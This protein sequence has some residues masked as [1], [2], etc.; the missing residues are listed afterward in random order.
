MKPK[1]HLGA[2]LAAALATLVGGAGA[3]AKDAGV[4]AKPQAASAPKATVAGLELIEFVPEEST[5]QRAPSTASIGSLRS[6]MGAPS[7]PAEVEPN[8]TAAT[9]TPISGTTVVYGGNVYPAADVDFYS[10]TA[11]AGDRIYAATQTLFDAS[12]SGDSVLELIGTDGTTV[13]EAD[14]NDGTFNASSSSIAGRQ[15]TVAGTYFLR[16]R[17]NV[18]TGTIRPYALHFRQQSAAP[19]AEVEPNNSTATATPIPASGHVS[20]AVT[21][22]SPGESD[23][24]SISLNAGDSVYL[25]LDMDPERDAVVWNGRLGFALFG[26]PPANQIL[27]ANDVNAGSAGDPNSE[28]FFFTVKDA[29]TYYVYVDSVVAAGLGVTATYNLNVSVLPRVTTGTCTTY[30]STD[31]PQTIPTGPGSVSSTITVPGNPRIA[32]LD[33]AINLNHTFMQD[34]DVHLISPAGN[35]NGLFTDI[36]AA[37]VGGTQ[38]LMDIVLDDEAALPP[39]FA[40]SAAFR[41][42]PELAYRLSWFDGSNAGGT[43]TLQLRDDA[44]GDGGTLNSWSITVCE[45]PPPQTC[46]AGTAQ[47]TVYS[48]DFEAGDGGFTHSG[49]QDEWERGLPAFAPITTC[50]SGTN[51][52]KTDLDNTYNASSSQDL[53]SPNINL[54]GLQPPVYVNWAQRYHMESTNFDHYNV[55]AR[56]VGGANPVNLFEWLDATMNNTVGNPTTTIGESSGWSQLS[57]RVDSLAGTNAELLFHVDSDTTV[58][59]AGVAIDDVSVTACRALSADLAITKTD[60]VASAVPG[61]TTTY[62]ITASNAGPDPVAAA[63]VADTFPAACVSPTWT[64]V[65]AGGGTCTANGSGNINQS[66]NLPAGGSVTFTA[67]CPIA[68]TATGSLAN[69]ATVSG[70]AIA[71]PTPGNNSATDTDTLTPQANLGIT[72]TNGVTQ[73][74]AGANTVYT[75]VASNAGPSAAP[76]ST[77][78]DTAPAACTTF[79]WTCVG[80]GGGICT[81]N[82]SGS[83]NDAVNLPVGGTATYTVTC[84]VSGAAAGN[85]VNTATVAAAGG[86][87]DPTPANNSATDTDTILSSQA[88]VSITK[89][90]GQASDVPGTSISYTIVA[91]NAGPAGAP[92]VT[93]ADTFAASL[94]GVTWTCTGAGG[95]TCTA[96]GAGNINDTANLPNGASVTYTVNATIAAN[97]TGTLSNTA[98]ATVGGAITDPNAAN[99]SAT[100]TTTLT[101]QADLAI[102]L[103][104]TPDPVTAGTNLTYV[105]T[106]TNNGPSDATDVAITLPLPANTTLVSATVSGG[107]CVATTCTFAGATAPGASRSVTYVVLVA[108]SVA[109]GSTITATASASSATT[110]PNGANNSASTTTDVI[111]VADLVIGLTSSA[112]QVLINVPV[113]FTATSQN[114]GPSDAQ[115]VSITLTLTPDFRYSSHVATGATCTTPQIGTTG[116]IVCT[117]AGATA[118]GVTR[119]LSVVAYSNNEG[120]T[121]VN[122][123]TTSNTTDPV[124]NNNAASQSVVVGFP[125]N[126][127]PTL[128]Q[129]GLLLLGLLVGLMGFVAI[130]RQG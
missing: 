33:V 66:V 41:I 83:I 87:T 115:N 17:H 22:V 8:G 71:D 103:T 6:A 47:T 102:T 108:A 42:Q 117:W 109:N 37:T 59:L 62:T 31:V 48:Q 82:G 46:P 130:R 39:A 26:N 24:F 57:R 77:V 2:V 105:A 79:T 20:G 75:I 36:G 123:S 116:A 60:G 44:T 112:T 101:P 38:T 97:A 120:N 106:A 51:C 53:L 52:W 4:P 35:D 111:A 67:L 64:C 124:A 95:G 11:A 76:G 107:T 129:Y 45:P 104:D 125:F 1:L 43:W 9:A 12:A 114:L 128:S 122:A 25:S 68:S 28:V 10:F 61:T 32:D 73:V 93:V 13:I 7:G 72:K 81:A 21:A 88:D 54:A 34:L 40:M 50:N 14:N 118:P 55:T 92:S 18:G 84:A 100:D 98:T 63:T 80:A 56:E 29:G 85:L 113:T 23:F 16:V 19:T 96:N 110:D 70:G 94:T 90:D 58:Q 119:T 78:A 86:I 65:G 89:T 74:N 91:S 69:T 126:E 3:V 27:L 5:P 49:A 99:N 121:A 15:I 30:T 127:I